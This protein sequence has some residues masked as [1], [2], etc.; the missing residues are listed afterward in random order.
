MAVRY[1]G[2]HM[3]YKGVARVLG[4]TYWTVLA[5][6]ES[7][8]LT[9]GRYRGRRRSRYVEAGSV[10]RHIRRTVRAWLA[11]AYDTHD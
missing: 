6:V 10:V 5:M 8:A 11:E 1:R 3:S 2:G 4:C 9:G 7:G